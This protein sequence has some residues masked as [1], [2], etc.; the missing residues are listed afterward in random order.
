MQ[1]I[2][3]DATLGDLPSMLSIY[4]CKFGRWLDLI[5]LSRELDNRAG[6]SHTFLE[7]ET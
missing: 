7:A 3:R 6:P 2:V 4:A 5:F 1:V